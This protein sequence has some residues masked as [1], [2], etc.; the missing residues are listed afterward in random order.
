[1]PNC[2]KCGRPMATVLKREGGKVQTYYE[3]PACQAEEKKVK[4]S[5]EKEEEGKPC[6]ATPTPSQSSGA[7]SPR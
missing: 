7:R 3:C 1:M 6:T 2:P 5:A 4:E